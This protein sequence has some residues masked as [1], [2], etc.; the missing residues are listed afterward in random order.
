MA[1]NRVSISEII[2]R[3]TGIVARTFKKKTLSA[4]DADRS[5]WTETPADKE[6]KKRVGLVF[7]SCFPRL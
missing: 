4:K 6:R 3:T 7:F 5:G 2:L 1:G